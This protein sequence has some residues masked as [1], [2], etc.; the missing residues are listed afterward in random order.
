M[1]FIYATNRTNQLNIELEDLAI[2]AAAAAA[3]TSALLDD[4]LIPFYTRKSARGK[5]RRV[6]RPLNFPST[7]SCTY[8]VRLSM[9][10]VEQTEGPMTHRKHCKPSGAMGSGLM[11]I[12]HISNLYRV[13][14]YI[15][16]LRTE[17]E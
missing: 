14:S 7:H 4:P 10:I 3:T 17:A 5:K 13:Y 2:A 9:I 16:E 12:I 11:G 15:G 6:N 8:H 1:S